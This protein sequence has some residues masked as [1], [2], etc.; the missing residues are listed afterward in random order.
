VNIGRIFLFLSAI[1]GFTTTGGAADWTVIRK[2]GRDYVT[3]A[4]VAQFYR[5]PEYTRVSRNVSLRG[6]R[7]GI[8]RRLAQASSPSTESVFTDFP[9]IAGSD[10]DL[11]SAMDINKII[12]PVLRPSKIAGAQKLKSS[13]WIRDTV[14]AIKAP[15]IGGAVRKIM[16]SMSH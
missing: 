13:C 11:I 12:E 8:A 2:E 15:P 6:E 5:F 4:N 7:R 10:E 9:I 14:E 3:F 16:L 1:S